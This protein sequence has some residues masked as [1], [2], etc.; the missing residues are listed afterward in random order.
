MGEKDGC[1]KDGCEG[2]GGGGLET[3]TVHVCYIFV[4][5]WSGKFYFYH[6]K[7]RE[8]SGNFVH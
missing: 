8:K 1:E 3:A 4:F 6:G 7:V 5:I 2:R